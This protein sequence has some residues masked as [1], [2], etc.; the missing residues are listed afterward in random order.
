MV[1][2]REMPDDITSTL[3]QDEE[4]LAWGW[5]R[6][7]R[8]R[9][10]RST[11]IVFHL[12]IEIFDLVRN[13]FRMKKVRERSAAAAFPLERNMA[14]CIASQRILIWKASAHPRRILT[15]LGEVPRVRISSAE[16]PFSSDA[17]WQTLVLKTTDGL[18]IRLRVDAKGAPSFV[19]LL[20]PA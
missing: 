20:N 4:P 10:N 13:T 6:Y 9:T 18:R 11:F 17:A 16:L 3:N 19:E 5:V 12:L 7:P 14:M 2:L 8:A 15:Y 1:D